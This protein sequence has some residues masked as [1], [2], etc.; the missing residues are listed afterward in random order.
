MDF[1][2]PSQPH[3]ILTDVNAPIEEAMKLTASTLKKSGVCLEY[4]LA[5]QLPKCR[6]DPHQFEEVIVNIINNAADSM[7][8]VVSGKKIEIISAAHKDHIVIRIIDSGPGI[9]IENKE[10]I[11]DPFFTTKAD[12]T[13]I[14]LSIC[15]RIIS[16]HRGEIH[17][18]NNQPSGTEFKILIPIAKQSN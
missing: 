12:S 2:R 8:G 15:R 14:G 18:Q 6:L 11:F 10:K 7:R 13:G 4:A 5:E 3:Y 1:S 17:V 9:P 16:D